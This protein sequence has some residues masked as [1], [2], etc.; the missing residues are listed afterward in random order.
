MKRNWRAYAPLCD[1]PCC[2]SS[3]E[4]VIR[5]EL[6]ENPDFRK[7]W[8]ATPQEPT[9]IP[10]SL[11]LEIKMNRWVLHPAIEKVT[12]AATLLELKTR[13]AFGTQDQKP[14]PSEWNQN[15]RK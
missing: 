11:R 8:N 4:D 2:A 5:C 15:L 6:S 9:R 3:F 14:S 13:P 7:V 12:R 10:P 1:A